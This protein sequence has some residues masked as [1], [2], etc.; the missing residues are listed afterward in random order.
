[1][2]DLKNNWSDEKMQSLYDFLQQFVRNINNIFKKSKIKLP[3]IIE[4]YP[5][6]I[7]TNIRV[8][9]GDTY[10]L[11]VSPEKCFVKKGASAVDLNI[12]ASESFWIGVMKGEYSI[13]S[14]LPTGKVKIRGLRSS[15]LP[16]IFLSSLIILFSNLK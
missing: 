16:L 6:G 7:R 2:N 1:M 8:H 11:V 5:F 12:E 4:L 14:G 13:V 9:N 3:N 10:Y 15:I